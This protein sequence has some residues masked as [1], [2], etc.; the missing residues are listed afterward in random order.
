MPHSPMR[1][2]QLFIATSL[3]GYIAGPGGDLGWLFHDADY[4]YTPFHARVDTV[5]MGR[6]TY[7]TALAFEPWPYA[8]RKAVVFTRNGD[9][10]VSSPDTVATSRAPADV[11]AELRTRDG[12]MLWLVGGG[13]LVRACL[14]ADLVDDLVVS[15]HP[16]ILGGGTPLVP[17]G[18]RRTPLTLTAERRFPSGLVQ[19]VYRVDRDATR[20]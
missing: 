6:R 19:L 8:G 18:T 15:I 2:L 17:R 4:G 12:G 1:R 16:L 7:E 5:L 14:D 13:E 20:G 9:L 11:V 3:D 10:R